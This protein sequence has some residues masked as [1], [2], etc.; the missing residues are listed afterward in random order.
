MKWIGPAIFGIIVLLCFSI[1]F[2]PS[3]VWNLGTVAVLSVFA[4][5]IV[6]L[7]ADIRARKEPK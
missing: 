5:I 3:W 4:G 6:T 1:L 2:E 7:V